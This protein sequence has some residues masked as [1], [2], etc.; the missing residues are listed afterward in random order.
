[1][2]ITFSILCTKMRNFHS[3]SPIFLTKMK[4]LPHFFETASFEL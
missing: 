4:R 2:A 1:M 3:N